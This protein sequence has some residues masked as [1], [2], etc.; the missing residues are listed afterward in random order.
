VDESRQFLET[1]N[2][3][4]LLPDRSPVYVT[5]DGGVF[6]PPISDSS[7]FEAEAAHRARGQVKR[8]TL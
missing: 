1:S 6:H 5:R 3:E 4:F 8:S 7:I 2:L